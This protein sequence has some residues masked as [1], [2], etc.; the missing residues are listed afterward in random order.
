MLNE[1]LLLDF[2]GT[3]SD[4]LVGIC[5]SINYALSHAPM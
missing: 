4:P 1:P 5:R 3:I 2:D